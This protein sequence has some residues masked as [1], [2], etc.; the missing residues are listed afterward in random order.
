MTEVKFRHCYYTASSFVIS[1]ITL[2]NSVYY[3]IVL[4][5]SKTGCWN[6]EQTDSAEDTQVALWSAVV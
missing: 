3:L 5:E 2:L 1:V 4:Y 6:N